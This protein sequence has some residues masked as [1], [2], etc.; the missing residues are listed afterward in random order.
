MD[1]TIIGLHGPN[2]FTIPP[3]PYEQSYICVCVEYLH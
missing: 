3:H 1:K 2:A